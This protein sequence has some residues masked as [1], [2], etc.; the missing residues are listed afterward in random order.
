MAMKV[1]IVSRDVIKPSS[2]TPENQRLYKLSFLDQFAPAIYTPTL[3]FYSTYRGD[4]DVQNHSKLVADKTQRLKMSLSE[5]LTQFYPLAGRVKDNSVIECNDEG[6]EFLEAK[7][8]CFL[9]DILKQPDEY[10]MNLFLPIEV[11][12]PKAGLS[13]LLLIQA[14][15]FKCGGLAIGI[16]ISHKIADGSTISTFIKGWSMIANGCTYEEA[17][18]PSYVLGDIYP[19]L[20]FPITL[21]SCELRK[22]KCITTRYVFSASKIAELKAQAASTF[23]ERPTRVE[24]VLALLWKSATMAARAKFGSNRPTV[25]SQLVNI[26]KRLN[27]PLPENSIGNLLGIFAVQED[28][29]EIGLQCLVVQLRKGLDEYSN[30]DV[31]KLQQGHAFN[32]ICEAFQKVENHLNNYG[33]DLF[34]CTS[35]CKFGFYDANFGWGRPKWVT[36]SMLRVKNAVILMDASDGEGIEALLTLSEEEMA[37]VEK[38]EELLQFA[39]VNPSIIA[40]TST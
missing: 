12:S 25:L 9:S 26:R 5:T 14:N 6:A 30:V 3:L 4:Q 17:T 35:L 8:N 13:P 10:S 32:A 28:G 27:P 18:H 39:S 21:P 36:F 15:F 19:S 2:P 37:L 24:A 29:R 31:K 34:A 20:D 38:N 7:V 16:S 33:V 11:E 23:V 22:G 1:E 40:C